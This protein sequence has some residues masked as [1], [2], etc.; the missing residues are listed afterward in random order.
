M[1]ARLP[2]CA[3]SQAML[4]AEGSQFSDGHSW[5]NLA[6]HFFESSLSGNETVKDIRGT[7]QDK[8]ANQFKYAAK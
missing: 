6:A 8:N 3:G 1:N 7:G 2:G 5:F 4:L